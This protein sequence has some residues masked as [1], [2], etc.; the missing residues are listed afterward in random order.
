MKNIYRYIRIVNLQAVLKYLEV[1]SFL[2]T[3]DIF[4][5]RWVSRMRPAENADIGIADITSFW[6]A[7][8][9]K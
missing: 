5:S 3:L 8:I 6:Q 9:D 2:E 4:I 7:V 1:D